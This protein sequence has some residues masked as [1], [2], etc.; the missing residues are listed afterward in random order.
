MSAPRAPARDNPPL[1]QGQYLL[2]EAEIERERLGR[3]H[4]LWRAQVLEGWARAGFAAGMRVIDVGAGPGHA[5]A[6][7]AS[8]VGPAGSVTAVERSSESIDDLR[9]R[10]AGSATPIR[11]E[12]VDLM[13]DAIPVD[14]GL[15]DASWCRWVAMFV[16]DIDC[17]VARIAAALKPGGVA[18]FHEYANYRTYGL[19]PHSAEVEE[20]VTRAVRGLEACGGT[21]NAA[22]PVVTALARHGFTIEHLRLLP[23]IARPHEPFWQWPSGFIRIFAPRLVSLGLWDDAS[24]S[25]L[26]ATIDLAEQDGTSAFIGPLNCEIIAR[27]DPR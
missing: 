14:A 1:A 4:E 12:Q 22:G 20:F 15:H 26:L 5:T 24:V 6:D 3:Q 19:L 23:T 21:V 9:R 27:L 11:V 7:L 2:G 16:P 25:K 18:V 13:T 10:F 17:L 8:L